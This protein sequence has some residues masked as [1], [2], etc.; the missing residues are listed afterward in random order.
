MDIATIVGL[1]AGTFLIINGMVGGGNSLASF[2]DLPSVFIT[3]GGSTTAMLI[4]FPF[5]QF[6]SAMQ[7]VRW[8]FFTKPLSVA[9][10]IGQLVA[11]AEKAR[12]EGLLALEEEAQQTGDSFLQKGIQLVV[13]GTDPALV[14]DI[15]EIEVSFVEERH[16]AN[17]G[18]FEA[19]ASLA[20]AFGMIGTVIGLIQ[21]LQ[22]LQDV[23]K[24]GP[25]M[26]VAL[27][28]TLY[29]ALM[30]NFL[31]L[32]IAGKLGIRSGEEALMR[33]IMIEGILSI[34]AG[35]NPRIV[36]EK[37]KSFLPPKEREGIQ[38]KKG[39]EEVSA[40]A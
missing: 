25:S 29:G 27:I 3:I 8:A 32:P 9:D 6:V 38:R 35:E 4:N 21:M 1:I 26:A 19:W 40:G 2:F 10:V 11:F 33:Q 17:K 20:P 31:F 24:I 12:R 13:D 7:S 39:T 14:K 30:A 22:N 16:K 28:T 18:F 36:E 37:L 34:Q 5:S 23:S 15:L